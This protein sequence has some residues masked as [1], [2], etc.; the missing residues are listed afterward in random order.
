MDSPPGTGGVVAPYKKMLRSYLKG[1]TGW[2]FQMKCFETHSKHFLM[3]R[4]PLL[5]KEG[6]S[7][8]ILRGA[9]KIPL[10]D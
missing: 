8:D 4:S 9:Q 1:Q 7:L 10:L 6:W 2:S 5:C 3:T